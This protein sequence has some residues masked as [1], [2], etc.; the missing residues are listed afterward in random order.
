MEMDINRNLRG[1]PRVLDFT[2]CKGMHRLSRNIFTPT[3]HVTDTGHVV[4]FGDVT[5]CSL[6]GYRRFGGEYCRQFQANFTM[7]TVCR[8]QLEI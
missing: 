4:V 3:V 2:R 1:T 5:S 7:K 6:G 8:G